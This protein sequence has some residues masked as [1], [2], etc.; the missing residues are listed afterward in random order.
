MPQLRIKEYIIG[1]CMYKSSFLW[2]SLSPQEGKNNPVDLCKK[3]GLISNPKNN[4]RDDPDSI[5]GGNG[6]LVQSTRILC[7]LLRDQ[8]YIG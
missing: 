2:P 4:A 7:G 5:L 3:L 1:A 6:S 8:A